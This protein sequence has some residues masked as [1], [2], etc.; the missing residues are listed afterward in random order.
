MS[1]RK[2]PAEPLALMEVMAHH[3][4]SEQKEDYRHDNG[5][6]EPPNSEQGEPSCRGRYL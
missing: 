1:R 4:L 3:A 6:H 5:K 2:G